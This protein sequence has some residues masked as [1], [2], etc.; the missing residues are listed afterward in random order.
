M[1]SND[2]TIEVTYKVTGKYHESGYCSDP[3]DIIKIK[4]YTTL[5]SKKPPS[6]EFIESNFNDD[7]NLN[8]D[9][10]ISDL[11]FTN[12]CP[13]GSGYCGCYKT[14]S[15]ISAKLVV[16]D[17]SVKAQFLSSMS[18]C[19]TS[20]KPVAAKPVAAKP[21]SH[22][23]KNGRYLSK[24]YPVK[25]KAQPIVNLDISSKK[26]FSCGTYGHI[27]KICPTKFKH[28]RPAFMSP[29]YIARCNN[30]KCKFGPTCYRRF[31]TKN[32]CHYNHNIN[33]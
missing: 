29:L 3:S 12:S 4:S 27:S 18:D 11:D 24:T 5:I 9:Y 15:A 13:H 1:T 32:P 21:S 8:Y 33:E 7:G 19:D 28:N 31:D 22:V 16:I 17:N 14:Y 25:T 20:K 10:D 6:K 30:I 26:C 2:V 23:F